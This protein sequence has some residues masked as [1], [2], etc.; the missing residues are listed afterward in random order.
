MK[1]VAS[2]FVVFMFSFIALRHLRPAGIV[3]Y[4]GIALGAVSSVLQLAVAHVSRAENLG[5]SVKDALLTFLLIYAFVF[6]IP[7]TVDRSY[8]VKMIHH[9]TDAH[10]GLTR[11]DINQLYVSDFVQHGGIDQRLKEQTA[12]GTLINQDDRYKLTATGRILAYVFRIM[13]ILYACGH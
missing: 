1:R 2:T 12:T 6:T 10:S 4:Q 11:N 5:V 3:F 9:L 8:S 7:T 13:E